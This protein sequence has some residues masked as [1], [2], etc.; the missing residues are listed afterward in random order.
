MRV[1]VTNEAQEGNDPVLAITTAAARL[2]RD[3]YGDFE[4]ADGRTG[5][6]VPIAVQVAYRDKPSAMR[7]PPYGM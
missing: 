1:A 5:R 6:L 7:L 4:L 2:T 3:G